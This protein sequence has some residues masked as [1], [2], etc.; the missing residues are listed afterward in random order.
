MLKVFATKLSSYCLI[1]FL[2]ACGRYQSP[3]AKPA[4]RFTGNVIRFEP[5]L[6]A[7]LDVTTQAE[8][9]A[10]GFDWSEGPLWIAK[11]NMLLFSDASRNTIYKWT[12]KKGLGVYLKPSGYTDSAKSSSKEPGSNGLALDENGKLVLCQQGNRQI[13][14]MQTSV[15]DPQPFFTP[16]AKT[17]EGKRLNSPNDCVVS[18]TGEIY[19]T[20]PPYGLST[21]DDKDPGKEMPFNGVYKIKKNG[22]II[23]LIDSI[24][25]PNG[26]A[27]FPGE[28]R[29]LVANTDY[30]H[31]EWCSYDVTG[32][33]LTNGKVFYNASKHAKDWYGAPDGLK[34][35]RQGIVFASGPG[36]IYIFD[37]TGKKLG[38]LRLKNA[39]S[40]CALSS[41]EKTLF[42][43][44][45]DQILKL[46]LK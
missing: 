25:R 11:Q 5:E 46:K 4:F 33:Q 24:S 38:L 9:I 31:Q 43:T 36:G 18:H 37:S 21:Q 29:L 16:L 34:I 27:F 14:R 32:D 44:S 42:I 45:D 10:E 3:T 35:N 19:F 7:V 8:I 15:K 22:E 6:D 1:F 41:D 12:A 30:A 40:N 2:C 13:A 17:Y 39:S 28:K 26:L 23:L 20:D